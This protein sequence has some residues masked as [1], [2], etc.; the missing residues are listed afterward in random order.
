LPVLLGLG[1]RS[2]SVAPA[3]LAKVKDEIARHG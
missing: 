1:L 2:I 3:P